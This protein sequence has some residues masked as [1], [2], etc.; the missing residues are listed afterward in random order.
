[1]VEENAVR[2]DLSPYEQGRI[3]WYARNAG[4]FPTIEE[5]VERLYPTAN[6]VKRT[7]LRALAEL[8][9]EFDG[10]LT[11]PEKL[12]LRQALRIAGALRDGFGEAM[13]TALRQSNLKDPDTQWQLLLPYLVEAE[14]LHEDAEP[15]PTPAPE[16]R[17]RPI[18]TSR[19]RAGLVIRRE[20][21]REGWCLHFTGKEA[22]SALIDRVFL[23]I[24]D[25][26]SPRWAACDPNRA[27]R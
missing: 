12:A 13:V 1:M 6:A 19:P 7:R 17:G 21:T 18:R 25:I 2:A 23:E 16:G 11:A 15:A 20:M 26:F 27:A 3:A 9:E 8:P 5:A 10:E 22:K 14:R 4:V 24:E